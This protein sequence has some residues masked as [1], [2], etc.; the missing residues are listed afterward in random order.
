MRTPASHGSSGSFLPLRRAAVLGRKRGALLTS[1]RGPYAWATSCPV[2]K[3]GL[4]FN[5]SA[6]LCGSSFQASQKA[7]ARKRPTTRASPAGTATT[8]PHAPRNRSGRMVNGRS[9]TS[10]GAH[11]TIRPRSLSGSAAERMIDVCSM[12]KRPTPCCWKP[13]HHRMMGSLTSIIAS[14]V[15]S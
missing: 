5:A 2:M 11:R 12:M 4:V 1:W 15:E 10:I 3:P 9:T 14:D 6:T 7:A 13:C 8:A